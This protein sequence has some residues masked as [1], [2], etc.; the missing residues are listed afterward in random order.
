MALDV[1]EYDLVVLSSQFFEPKIEQVNGHTVEVFCL[2]NEPK[3]LSRLTH[4]EVIQNAALRDGL[5]VPTDDEI[6]KLLNAA[7]RRSIVKCLMMLKKSRDSHNDTFLFAAWLKVAA[8]CYT[9]GILQI[10]GTRPMPV[11]ELEQLRDLGAADNK[12]ASGLGTAFEAI[13]TDYTDR[14]TPLRSK[15]AA[16]EFLSRQYDADLILRKVDRLEKATKIGDAYYYLGRVICR[17]IEADEEKLRSYPKL[18]LTSLGLN[19]DADQLEKARTALFR[20]A[21]AILRR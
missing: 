1:C 14:L 3:D 13:G 9:R 5:E 10:A 7:G 6:K 2:K 8:Y 4:F 15:Q 12:S 19:S 17:A 20:S 21:A 11:H 16:A 18:L